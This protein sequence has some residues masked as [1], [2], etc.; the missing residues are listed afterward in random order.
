MTIESAAAH[1]QLIRLLSALAW[2]PIL[3]C[4]LLVRSP[5]CVRSSF[6]KVKCL[7]FTLYGCSLV[8]KYAT[9]QKLSIMAW[10]RSVDDSH[11]EL[12]CRV[13]ARDEG[14]ANRVP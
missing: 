3:W 11:D 13:P 7:P 12:C 2:N 4:L 8:Q 5:T 10:C 6:S 14:S 9:V 1:S